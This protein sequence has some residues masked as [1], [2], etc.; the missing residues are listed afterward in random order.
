[1]MMITMAMAAT[2]FTQ[3]ASDIIDLILSIKRVIQ[4]GP[5]RHQL[6]RRHHV[7]VAHHRHRVYQFSK[8]EY[9]WCVFVLSDAMTICHADSFR[10]RHHLKYGFGLRECGV[11]AYVHV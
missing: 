9:K 6:F 3:R 10:R 4:F 2:H 8:D 1:M 5:H 7:N 11:R